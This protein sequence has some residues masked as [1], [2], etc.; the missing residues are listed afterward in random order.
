MSTVPSGNEAAF[1]R[2][3]LRAA[4]LSDDF[5]RAIKEMAKFVRDHRHF[6][7]LLS[8]MEPGLRA[9]MYE[10]MRANLRFTA[11][12]LDVYIANIKTQA[13]REQLPILGPNGQLVPFKPASDA[14]SV[15]K[16]AEDMLAAAMAKKTLILHCSKCTAEENFHMIG[17]ETAVDVR[18]KAL[19][20][21]WTLFPAEICPLCTEARKPN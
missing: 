14:S 7:S 12:P 19:T 15:Q 13:E 1:L 17:M 18:K 16:Q 4:G 21:G 6:E 5:G 11:L 10:A 2:R 8:E 9:D 20:A 3:A